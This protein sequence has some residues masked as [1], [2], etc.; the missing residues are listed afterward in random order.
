MAWPTAHVHEAVPIEPPAIIA[1]GSVLSAI[2]KVIRSTGTPA[3]SAAKPTR[4]VRAPVPMSAASISISHR[5]SGSIVAR[6]D[7]GCARA[8]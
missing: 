4:A 6:A 2:R 5:P 8:G 7:D 1:D 3:C